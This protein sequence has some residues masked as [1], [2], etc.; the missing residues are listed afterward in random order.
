MRALYGVPL[1]HGGSVIGVAYMGSRTAFEFSDED[2]LLFRS[3]ASRATSVI[4]QTRLVAD[5][6]KSVA[7]R[8]WLVAQLAGEGRASS[9][10]ST[11]FGFCP[12]PAGSSPNPVDYETTLARIARLVVPASRTGSSWICCATGSSNRSS[13]RTRTR[14]RSN[15]PEDYRRRF[16]QTCRQVAASPGY[17]ETASP[18]FT[19]TSPDEFLAAP[20]AA[21]STSGIMRSSA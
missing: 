1:S 15:L 11:G 12:K 9:R 17:C 10:S 16:R 21:M 5:L 20:P 14:R 13:S 3:M 2:R 18:S 8:D 19:K 6:E 7:D 4:V